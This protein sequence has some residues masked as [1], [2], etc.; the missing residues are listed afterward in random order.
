[1]VSLSDGDTL[2]VTGIFQPKSF[3]L[4][5][6]SVITTAEQLSPVFNDPPTLE[7]KD[8]PSGAEMS[9]K[10]YIRNVTVDMDRDG[11]FGFDDFII[12]A[13]SF[14][15][16]INDDKYD[17]RADLDGNGQIEFQDFIIF[18]QSIAPTMMGPATK[19]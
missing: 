9:T 17:A 12:F 6:D 15:T 10:I 1:M 11:G 18:A 4:S 19:K 13:G 7:W 3:A 16:S 14:G 8:F 5:P 2:K